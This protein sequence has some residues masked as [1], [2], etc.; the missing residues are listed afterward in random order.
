VASVFKE[1]LRST[2]TKASS[3]AIP[4][5]PAVR[6]KPAI[7]PFEASE[8]AVCYVRNTSTPAVR[9]AQIAVVRNGAA[10]RTGYRHMA[11]ILSEIFKGVYL[12]CHPPPL[13]TC[14]PS[15]GS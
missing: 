4:P 8:A 15:A 2:D 11:D 1:R 12:L 5:V 9:C 6:A 10:R 13:S 7:R 14:T 3:S